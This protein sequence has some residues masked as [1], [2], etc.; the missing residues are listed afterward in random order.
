MI[1]F[2]GARILLI[3]YASY[4]KGVRGVRGLVR[5]TLKI[6]WPY[7]L[8]TAAFLY[9]RIFM[10]QGERR[11]TDA[12]RLAAGYLSDLRYMSLRLILETVKDFFDTSI[13][14]WFATPYT[15]ISATRYSNL[16]VAVF[17]AGLVIAL[18]LLYRFLYKRKWGVDQGENESSLIRDFFLIGSFLILC[19]V[20]PVI[21]SGRQVDLFDTYKSYGL[22]PIPGVI[23]FI[24]AVVLML[25]PKFRVWI[26]IALLGISVST[27]VLNGYDWA[28][29]WEYQ[30]QMWW[31]FTWR[32]PDVKNDT[33]VMTYSTDGYN[34]QQDYE[35]W[36]PLNLIYRP[37]PAAAPSIQA[38]VLN[39]D[40]TYDILKKR[41]QDRYVRDIPLHLDFNNLLLISISPLSSC[42]HVIDGTMPVY[43]NSESLITEQVG[44]YSHLD[45]IV[46]TGEAPVPPASIF[47]SEPAHDWCYYY[48]KASLARQK[49]DWQEIGK[50]YKQVNALSLNTDDTSEL[51]PFLEGLVNL[52]RYD[53]ARTLYKRNIK[54]SAETRLAACQALARDPGYPATFGYNYE[55]IYQILCKE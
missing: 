2:E 28:R 22:H 42:L 46:P 24:T 3:G 12:G 53:D 30:R 27:Q 35:I 9:W 44:A 17:I 29:Y 26:V 19:A 8:V 6:A 4:Q 51:I 33:V 32:A 5:E 1:G 13:F 49:G 52:G 10:F 14:A 25:Q 16:G 50:L 34:P 41:V 37:D 11:A 54:G 48:Q 36:G 20:I 21:F 47:E 43:S 23:L 55:M 18:V 7:L 40:T 45:R 39:S 31:Q 38:E 15:M